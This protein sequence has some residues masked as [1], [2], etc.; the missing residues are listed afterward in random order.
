[1]VGKQKQEEVTRNGAEQKNVV[2][3]LL[4]LWGKREERWKV[5]LLVVAQKTSEEA[6]R[7]GLNLKVVEPIG[8]REILHGM[9]LV[10]TLK[11]KLMMASL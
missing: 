6:Q 9:A 10:E 11:A 2:G 3:L 1:M 7:R 5:N 8:V 4:V